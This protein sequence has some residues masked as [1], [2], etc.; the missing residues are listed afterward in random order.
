MKITSTIERRLLVNWRADPDVVQPILP[1]GL[2]PTIVGASAVVGICF[3]RLDTHGFASEGAAHRVGVTWD[4]PDGEVTGV[5]IWRRHTSSLLN[6]AVGGRLFPGVHDRARFHVADDGHRL[7]ITVASVAGV[8]VTCDDEFDSE[9]FATF[10]DAS[11]FFEQS[12]VGISPRRKI[13][14]DAVR[15]DTTRWSVEPVT[16]DG[17]WSSFYDD[18]A[19][20]PSGSIE[21][22]GALLMRD[23]AA[24][25]SAVSAPC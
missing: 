12:P 24:R 22:D 5:Y 8:D 4:A 19:V 11:A 3:V 21:L 25:W 6:H 18:T 14:H 1:D 16:V 9:V 13:G 20:F 2:R 7:S 15:L 10:D 23:T 17:A